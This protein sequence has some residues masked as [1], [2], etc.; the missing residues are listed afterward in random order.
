MLED[1]SLV[2][3]S[4]PGDLTLA[5]FDPAE[6]CPLYLCSAG[7]AGSAGDEIYGTSAGGALFEDRKIVREELG[8]SDVITNTLFR[9]FKRLSRESVA[10]KYDETQ[11]YVTL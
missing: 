10:K 5:R 2:P 9:D 4:G 11:I 1:L 7:E 8:F 6:F 3:A